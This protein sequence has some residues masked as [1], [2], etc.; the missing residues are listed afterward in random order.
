MSVLHKG[1]HD[2]YRA[3]SI[4]FFVLIPSFDAVNLRN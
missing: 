4:I 1:S 3:Y 2:R